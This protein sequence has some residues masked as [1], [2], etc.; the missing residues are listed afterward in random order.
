MPEF[1]AEESI[2]DA[3]RKYELAI[4]GAKLAVWEYEIDTKRL[5]LPSDGAEGYTAARYGFTSDVV[6]NVPESMLEMGVTET[7][8]QN[9]CRL[10]EEIRAGR[11]YATA[12]VWFHISED[13]EP[14]C[15]RISY[16]TSKDKNGRPVRAYGVSSDVTAQQRELEKFHQA[17]QSVLTANPDA[18]CT[19]Q[20]NLTRNLCYEGH[21][22][23]GFIL[24]S[25][26][27]ATADGLIRN[28][29]KMICSQEDR[30][31]FQAVFERKK[32][33]AAFA[34]GTNSGHV[35]YRR[36]GENGKPIWVRTHIRMLR[37]P[38]TGDV[39]GAI[40]SQDISREVQQ[41]Q[42]FRIITSEEY[43]L[44][45]LLHLDTKKVEAIRLGPTLPK[46]YY[47]VFSEAAAVSDFDEMRRN[48]AKNWVAPEDRQKY[49][50]GTTV[51]K[52]CGELDRSGRYELTVQGHVPD[53]PEGMVC[54]KL[55]HYYLDDEHSAVLI[56]D[57]DVTETYR[58][59]QRE[60][61][62]AKAETER[63]TDIMDSV[64]SGIC[65]LHM[66]DPE[67]LLLNYA[68][69][70]MY[71]MLGFDP[72]VRGGSAADEL[73]ALYAA[74]GFAG[75]H[76]DDA[77]RV[78]ETFRENFEAEHF[79]VDNY[80]ARGA[81]GSYRWL[82]EEVELREVRADGRLFYATY[83]DVSREVRLQEELR[84]QLEKEKSLRREAMAA[85][86]AKSEFLSRMS[87]DIRT[88]LNGIIGM[89]Y[90]AGKQPNPPE[91]RDCLAKIDTS[92]KFLL[93]L[94]NDILDMSKAE[95]GKIEL[96]PE[97]YRPEDF[98]AYLDAVVVPLCRDKN[99]HFVI[100]TQPLPGVVVLLDPLRINQVF[101]NLLSNAVKFT[102]EGGTIVFRLHQHIAEDGRLAMDAEVSDSGIGMSEAFQKVLFEPF[103]QEGRSDVSESRGSGL[104]LAIVKKML[105]LMGG[106]ISVRSRI[107]E[108]T[109]FFLHASFDWIP[110]SEAEN[111][112]A[113][114][115][116]TR[117]AS[118]TGRHILLCEDHPL[119]QEIARA[120]L[121]ERG[122][123]VEI[124]DNGQDGVEQFRRSRV[125]F[126]DAILMDIRMP[127]MDGYEATRQIRALARADAR[128]VPI[129][130][131]TADAFSDDVQKCL[132]AGMNGHIA[133]PIEPEQ[134]AATILGAL[135]A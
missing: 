80:R 108:G 45:A 56:I 49:L 94:V 47:N 121:E 63:V 38:D 54:R 71:R 29:A 40:Y 34:A 61:E 113:A 67:H 95:S 82:S 85:S 79:A 24:A 48:G 130:A 13:A 127:V 57:S 77:E 97:P 31:H 78:K 9:F 42:I 58:R 70:R 66:P 12:D 92:S 41:N 16:Y 118:L 102:P 128:T 22:A 84:R 134:M 25:L 109:S 132:A 72:P 1:E 55:Q 35:E 50:S 115:T 111:E 52:I 28:N 62:L 4:K 10:F 110:E 23:S 43:D 8:R 15:E 91:T 6:E 76:P 104:G 44:I 107:G 60:V 59:Q 120:L 37:N 51:E 100:D 7:D 129:V 124:A 26:Q 83:R 64:S 133:K 81:D 96:H 99:Q 101:F 73:Y 114:E 103:R 131:M 27:A 19:F 2:L 105:D 14:H 68:N 20:L 36:F 30:E 33:L 123:V 89:T 116:E 74:D 88:P 75:I 112:K 90:F 18:L 46:T 32:L 53:R 39:E 125:G 86:E 106:T 21:G 122:C 119:N 135:G 5:Y 87:H 17:I 93:G 69:R 98:L 117:P 65:V 126:Y 11:E 3:K